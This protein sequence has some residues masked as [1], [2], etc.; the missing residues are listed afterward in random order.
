MERFTTLETILLQLKKELAEGQKLDIWDEK[1]LY[2]EKNL[3]CR[4]RYKL[5]DQCILAASTNVSEDD[6][7]HLPP[8]MEVM[9][10]ELYCYGRDLVD[11]VSSAIKQRPRAAAQELLQALNYHSIND[12][13]IDFSEA[14]KRPRKWNIGIFPR[15]SASQL[16]HELSERKADV[17]SRG[18]LLEYPAGSVLIES[19]DSEI[20]SLCNLISWQSEWA[21]YLYI[22]MPTAE[23]AGYWDHMLYQKHPISPIANPEDG[24]KIKQPRFIAN[25]DAFLQAFPKVEPNILA[26]YFQSDFKIVDAQRRWEQYMIRRHRQKGWQPPDPPPVQRVQPSDMYHSD[27][28][29]QVFDFLRYL[30]FPLENELIKL[31]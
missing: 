12:S 1:C 7:E 17:L 8:E 29:R 15:F 4:S 27:D 2:A 3:C 9:G 10:L 24:K 18:Q 21:L 28:W 14:K 19:S 16:N 26:Q 20:I 5:S 22:S 6:I 25:I 13:F 11:V 30:G 23:K 31:P